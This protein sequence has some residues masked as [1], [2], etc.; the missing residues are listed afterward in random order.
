MIS[1][2]PATKPPLPASVFESVPILTSISSAVQPEMLL[3]A[4]ARLSQHAQAVRLV[5]HQQAPMFL[6]QVDDGR[7][8]DDVAVHAEDRVDD[9]QRAPPGRLLQLLRQRVHVVV[10]EHQQFGRPTC[11]TRPRCSRGSTGRR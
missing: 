7:Q 3:D 11:G 2:R 5:D 1:S 4:M 9:D 8:V 6:A 10:L